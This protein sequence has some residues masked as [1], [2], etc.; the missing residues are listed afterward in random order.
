MTIRTPSF[1]VVEADGADAQARRTVFILHGIFASSR[2]WRSVARRLADARPDL[3]LVL[4]DLHAHGDSLDAPGPHTLGRCAEE[5]LALHDVVGAP[6][7]V[8]GH[9]FGGKVAMVY[10]ERHPVETW[11]LDSPPGRTA[12]SG[13]ANRVLDVI[14]AIAE[15]LESRAQ[16]ETALQAA[17]IAPAVIAWMQTN[18]DAAPDGG[19]RF[20]FDKRAVVDLLADYRRT[21]CWPSVLSSPAPVVHVRGTRS[22]RWDPVNLQ[23]FQT[24]P[25]L[26]SPLSSPLER[27]S[28]AAELDAGHW[29][30]IDAGEPLLALLV[31]SLARPHE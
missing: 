16:L 7:A 26:S 17:G 28:S 25:P 4:V 13:E 6:A 11:V 18:V 30:H 20:R 9:S 14:L 21:D 22:D 31:A 15:P 8:I 23:R 24:L 3:R 1:R 5:L 29:V 19:L 12:E 10:S 2:S 27:G